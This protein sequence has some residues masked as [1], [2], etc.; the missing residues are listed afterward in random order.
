MSGNKLL[1]VCCFGC[2]A[3]PFIRDC[4]TTIWQDPWPA[5]EIIA[6]DPA[7]ADGSSEILRQCKA[8][9]PYPFTIMRREH[10]GNASANLNELLRAARGDF[11]LFTPLCDMQIPGAPEA[12]MERL[13][14]RD[15]CAFAAHTRGFQLE[16]A[17]LRPVATPLARLPAGSA[18][19]ESAGG[20]NIW[21]ADSSNIL[22]ATFRKSVLLKLHGFSDAM[23]KSDIALYAKIFL[24]QLAQPDSGFALLD[25][26]GFVRRGMTAGKERG[27]TLPEPALRPLAP[28]G[29]PKDEQEKITAYCPD[30]A[31]HGRI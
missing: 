3:A 27:A 28:G 22:A 4:L 31:E 11:V 16:G 24:W 26:P 7:P 1:S 9:S 17:K 21:A 8:E 12:R 25:E 6:L 15:S 13:L 19:G 18:W 2:G 23:L 14:A 30:G 10:S 5:K 29:R 20:N